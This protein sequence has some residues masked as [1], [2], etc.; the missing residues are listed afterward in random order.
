MFLVGITGGIAS[1]KS[2]V[3]AMLGKFDSQIIDSDDI[4]REV[5]L[6][7]SDGLI[8][9]VA[10]FG[11]QILEQDGSLSRAELGKIVFDDPEKRL[12]LEGILH[13]LIKARTLE[14][15]S[16]SKSDIVIYIVPL[17]VESKVDY[18]FD[19]VATIEAGT[20]NQTKRL[21]E[22]RGMSFE[23][24]NARITAQAS[25]AERVARADIR[26]D[27]SL[28]LADLEV[29]VSKLWS[30]ILLLAEKKAEH[31]KN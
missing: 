24:A 23:E 29:A 18:P 17:L 5:V 6:P 16:Q 1:G 27:G 2:T 3:A 21:M 26:I 11:P 31:G 9:V 12:T 19:F 7:G 13:P 14:R 8:K 4:A 10:E 15:I 22:S 28:G 30:K 20:E 25:E